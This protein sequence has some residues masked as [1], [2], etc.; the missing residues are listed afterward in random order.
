MGLLETD[1]AGYKNAPDVERFLVK[2]KPTYVGPWLLFAT[3][4]FEHWKDLKAYLVS[5]EPPRVLG[6]YENLSDEMAREYHDATYSV[7]L[8]AGFLFSKNVDLTHR[9]LIL[10]LGGGSGAYCIAAIRRYPHLEAIVMDF[11]PVTR[12]AAEFIVQWGLQDKISV[13]AGDFTSDPFPR[14]P[15]VIIQASN[16]PQ[17]NR[18]ALENVMKKGFDALEP[19]ALGPALWGLHEALFGSRGRAHSEKE[20]VSYLNNAGFVNV[21]VNAFIPGSLTRITGR[22][23]A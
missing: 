13:L 16:L 4:D 21:E 9:H 14:G 1:A 10:D 23:P 15:D 19:G 12:I 2:C 8:G 18:Q 11:E 22:K 5:D 7:G 17:Y 20:V 6:L 3:H